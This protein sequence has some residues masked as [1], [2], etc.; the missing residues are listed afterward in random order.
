MDRSFYVDN[1]RLFYD[2]RSGVTVQ[3][4]KGSLMKLIK[5]KAVTCNG[6]SGKSYILKDY[7]TAVYERHYC[8][9]DLPRDERDK[10]GSFLD[11]VHSGK[12]Y[13]S[14]DYSSRI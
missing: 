4:A 2:K 9:D 1:Y 12:Y 7:D 14:Y 5:I 10:V 13:A 11:K 6:L 8:E 3:L